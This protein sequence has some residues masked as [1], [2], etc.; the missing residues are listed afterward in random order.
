V[1]FADHLTALAH[2]CFQPVQ[3]AHGILLAHRRSPG[4]SPIPGQL[5][6][7]APRAIIQP[8]QQPV[9]TAPARG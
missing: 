6:T 9:T 7:R 5:P 4:R 1:G 3:F 2:R 8:A